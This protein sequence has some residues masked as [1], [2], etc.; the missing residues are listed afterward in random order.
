L[1]GPCGRT[2]PHQPHGTHQ[3]HHSHAHIVFLL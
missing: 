3:H 2:P 1:G